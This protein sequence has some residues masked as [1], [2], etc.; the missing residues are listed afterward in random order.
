M[1]ARI[2]SAFIS[3]HIKYCPWSDSGLID[4]IPI[5]CDSQTNN[6]FVE[7]LFGDI[8]KLNLIWVKWP[9]EGALSHI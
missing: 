8:N 4:F 7:K 5:D 3:L 1:H 2:G 9:S 6:L